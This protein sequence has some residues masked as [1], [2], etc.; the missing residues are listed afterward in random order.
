MKRIT[1]ILL[2]MILVP[3]AMMAQSVTVSPETGKLVAAKSDNPNETGF[4]NGLCAL[5]RHEQLALSLT[6]SDYSTLTTGGEFDTP[7]SNMCVNQTTGLLTVLGGQSNDCYLVLSLPKGYRFKKYKIIVQ[8]NLNGQTVKPTAN[9]TFTLGSTTKTL[10]EQSGNFNGSILATTE[11][12]AASNETMLDDQGQTVPKEYTLERLSESAN[13]MGNQLYFRIQHGST[14][15]YGLTIKSFAVEFTAEGTFEAEVASQTRDVAKSMVMVPFK[16]NKMDIGAVQSLT[17]NGSTFYAYTYNKVHD[18]DAYNYIYQDNAI[19]DGIPMDVATNKKISPVRVD[20]K[21][22]FAFENGI[23]YVEAPTQVYSQTGLTYPIGFRIVG[24]KFTPQWGSTTAGTTDSRTEYYITY[25][26]GSTTYYL[27]DQLRF[28]TTKFGW[29]YDEETKNIYTGIIGSYRYLSCEG[30]G[31]TRTL[32]LSSLNGSWY[33]LIVFTRNNTTYIGWDNDT[34]SQRYYLHGTTN[35]NTVPIVVRNNTND[36]ARWSSGQGTITIPGYTPGS[37]TLK[38]YNYAGT[39]EAA[40][41]T[42]NSSSDAGTA[43]DLTAKTYGY[44]NDAIK[45]EITGLAEGRK[46]L[47]DVSVSMQALNPYI[48]Q[49]NI[50]CHDS[51]NQLSLSQPFKAENF[52]VSGGK[53]KFYIPSEFNEEDLTFTFSDL[54][55]QYGDNTYYPDDETLHRD[56]YARYSFVTSSYFEPIDQNGDNGLYDNAYNP[57]ASYVNKVKTSTA[58]NIRYKFNNA[59][60]LSNTATNPPAVS[61]LEEYPFS[62]A[63]YVG[64]DDP[65]GST[66]KGNFI[67]CE[68]NAQDTESATYY[69]FVA[70]ETRY[71]IAPSTAWQHRYY[72]F[73]RMEIDL[74]T[75]NYDP[76]LTWSKVYDE[77]CY[78]KDG[79]LATDAMYGLKLS[80]VDHET[81]E[82]MT[83]YLTVKQIS[84]AITAALNK[85]DAPK[86][87]DQILYVDGSDLYSILNSK[88]T[89]GETTTEMTLGDLK[90]ELAENVL[91]Y[92]PAN[93]TSTLPNCAYKPNDWKVG[94]PYQ[95]G[96]NIVLTD[97][98]PFYAPFDINVDVDNII[99]HERKVTIDKNGKVTS[100]SIIMPF[101]ILID[102]NGTH[103]NQDGGSFKLHQMQADNCLTSAPEG[104]NVDDYVYFPVLKDVKKSNP[105]TPY[106]VE[107]TKAPEGEGADQISFVLSQKG[108][109]IKATGT[110]NANW[111]YTYAGE[112]G[113]GKKDNT[114]YTFNNHGSYSGKLLDKDGNFF[115]FAK[116]MFLRSNDYVYNDG[117]KVAPFRAYYSTTSTTTTRSSSPLKEFDVIPAALGDVN[118]DGDVT[119]ADAK[120]ILDVILGKEEPKRLTTV[121]SDVNTDGVVSVADV[122]ALVNMVLKKQAQVEE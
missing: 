15:Y 65:D 59:E 43:I 55:S 3:F 119:S 17:K 42:V 90:D 6:T 1:L 73:Y 53:F 25:T 98:R 57:N 47:V 87:S 95:A 60:N 29:M 38:I 12:M 80:T 84:D 74:Q 117:I 36:R 34:Q 32:S 64:S 24:A 82:E 2:S 93:T 94:D 10:V 122:T 71:N 51:D 28:T 70:D 23:Y 8:N 92:L 88:I 22:Y 111:D 20:G 4:Q 75:S 110:G 30:S 76:K 77:T 44:N 101:G 19:Q 83:G 106:L 35:A 109:T 79:A 112:S 18:I 14:A 61:Y 114:T 89:S 86:T 118:I 46:A 107:V 69:L 113:S 52:K 48:D 21:E 13:D 45:F 9:N 39:S 108:G 56:G 68:M 37:Y 26:S 66:K 72:A 102:E 91:I 104:V 33:N 7:C 58:G 120:G 103:T 121:M 5:W 115:Y 81:Q 105:N 67:A 40:S 78:N 116:N 96:S 97:N 54:W 41:K 31:D 85:T 16:T 27:N 63:N 50:I 99:L 100:A 11:E 49:M 62:A